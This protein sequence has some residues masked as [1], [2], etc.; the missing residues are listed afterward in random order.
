MRIETKPI[1][2]NTWIFVMDPNG[3]IY[4][5]DYVTEYRNGGYY[6]ALRYFG[7]APQEIV[8]FNHSSLVG[9]EPVASAGEIQVNKGRIELI[10]N[11]SGH[12]VPKPVHIYNFMCELRERDPKLNFKNIKLELISSGKR[13]KE[14]IFYS[15]EEFYKA[16]GDLSK[17]K[18]L[19]KD[20]AK[21][22]E[23]EEEHE[24]TDGG[25]VEEWYYTHPLSRPG[26]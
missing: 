10:S 8:G 12:Y 25:L 4:V 15:A 2:S 7:P 16:G 3:S 5:A 20:K 18:K 13:Y 11:K 23:V 22:E 1:V 17:C 26:A 19:K 14:G 24:L 21:D 6:D 9:G